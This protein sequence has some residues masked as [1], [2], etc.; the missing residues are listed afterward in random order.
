[1]NNAG[2]DQRAVRLEMGKCFK[3]LRDGGYG[4]SDMAADALYGHA[5]SGVW[6]L[7]SDAC[8]SLHYS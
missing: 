6:D 2:Q 8:P 3:M 1:M 4:I 5:D 7:G